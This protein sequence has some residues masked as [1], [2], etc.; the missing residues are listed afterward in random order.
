MS[1]LTTK[2]YVVEYVKAVRA[3][4]IEMEPY[5]EHK[6]DLRKNYAQNGWLTKD[7]MRQAMRAYRMLAKGDDLDQFTEFFDQISKKVGA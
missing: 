2:E 1:D 6:R 7:E 3:V 5:K 4:E